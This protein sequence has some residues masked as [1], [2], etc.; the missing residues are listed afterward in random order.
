MELQE[1][2]DGLIGQQKEQFQGDIALAEFD[3]RRQ[4]DVL[5]WAARLKDLGILSASKQQA[6]EHLML[7]AELALDQA[8]LARQS[9]VEYTAPKMIL[10]LQSQIDGAK[11]QLHADE[12]SVLRDRE[13]L[14]EYR[15]QLEHCTVRARTT[16]CWSTPTRTTTTRSSSARPSARA[17]TSSPFRT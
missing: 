9:L 11:A 2:R 15:E 8:A 17:R 14:E 6:E 7:Q 13:H 1:Y 3:V 10:D 16:A 5:A 4:E 12:F